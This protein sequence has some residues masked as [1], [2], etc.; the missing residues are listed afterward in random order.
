ML[1]FAIVLVVGVAY[2]VVSAT[3]KTRE[4]E[5]IWVTCGDELIERGREE[6]SEGR[7]RSGMPPGV[8]LL[9]AA[10]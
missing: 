6:S 8:S 1:V 2:V 7:P 5:R 3:R 4:V 10:V 9:V